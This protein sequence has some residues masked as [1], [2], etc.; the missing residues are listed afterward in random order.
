MDYLDFAASVNNQGVTALLLGDRIG[1]FGFF[2]GAWEALSDGIAYCG[3]LPNDK[4]DPSINKAL[5]VSDVPFVPVS[6]AAFEGAAV[7]QGEAA[8]FTF[9]KPFAFNTGLE[10]V[11]E[12]R[13]IYKAVILLNLAMLY[14]KESG[15]NDIYEK[16]ALELYGYSLEVLKCA[17]HLDCSNVL[18]ATLNN[19]AQIFF[20]RHEVERTTESLEKLSQSLGNAL[21]EGFKGLEDADID[22]L[23]LNVHCQRALVCAPGA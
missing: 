8:S 1:A 21:R 13:E 11:E 16:T 15:L 5:R 2:K 19:K 20:Q 12:H 3:F 4:V 23:L 17:V 18:I 7:R 9:Q 10:L 6:T 22:G 14:H